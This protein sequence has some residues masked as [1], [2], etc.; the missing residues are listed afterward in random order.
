MAPEVF[1]LLGRSVTAEPMGIRIILIAN[2]Y[3][4][5]FEIAISST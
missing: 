4:P 1:E 3:R 5:F 2:N